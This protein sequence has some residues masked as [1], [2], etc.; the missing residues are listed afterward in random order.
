M[1]DDLKKQII[2]LKREKSKF[3]LTFDEWTA[4]NIKDF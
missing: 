2:V 1:K 4:V 3:C